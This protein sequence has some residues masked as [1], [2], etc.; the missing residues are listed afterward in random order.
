MTSSVLMVIGVLIMSIPWL[1]VTYWAWDFVHFVIVRDPEPPEYID[2]MT[3][4]FLKALTFFIVALWTAAPFFIGAW[5][6][7]Q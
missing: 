6:V 5:L 3:N 4:D 2:Y 1:W 7:S